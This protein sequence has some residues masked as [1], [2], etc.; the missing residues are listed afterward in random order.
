ML[1][2]LQEEALIRTL[3]RDKKQKEIITLF[4][5]LQVCRRFI[6]MEFLGFPQEGF[7][8]N[9]QVATASAGRL[10]RDRV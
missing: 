7:V 5:A 1:A 4:K 8:L 9:T 6:N 10:T 3:G 2:L